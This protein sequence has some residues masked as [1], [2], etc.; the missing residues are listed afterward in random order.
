MTTLPKIIPETTDEWSVT[1]PL[2]KFRRVINAM[3]LVASKDESRL[4]LTGLLFEPV[5][6]GLRVVGTDSYR[7]AYASMSRDLT[8]DGKPNKESRSIVS[9][10][11]LK[12]FLKVVPQRSDPYSKATIT[13]Q[14]PDRVLVELAVHGDTT[15]TASLPRIGGEFPRYRHFLEH[16]NSPVVP[17]GENDTGFNLAYL[18]YFYKMA[19]AIGAIV[20]GDEITSPVRM[21][22]HGSLKPAKLWINNHD[23]DILLT[24]AIMPL[25]LP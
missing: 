4:L 24:C 5:D 8:F 20:H 18:N 2:G 7:I 11:A 16:D 6:E 17:D 3:A 9:G 12:N 10:A 23:A 21:E 14:C 25:R 15:F 22:S 1:M 19:S 13:F